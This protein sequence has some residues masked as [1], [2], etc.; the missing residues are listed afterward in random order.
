MNEAD[1]EELAAILAGKAGEEKEDGSFSR[2]ADSLP[3]TMPPTNT[4][5]AGASAS[6]MPKG[7]KEIPTNTRRPLQPRSVNIQRDDP[8]RSRAQ[9]APHNDTDEILP[10]KP[11]KATG[12]QAE[13]N[14]E[15]A[16]K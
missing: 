10:G 3:P 15:N 16:A 7:R 1:T 2:A 11:T 4:H 13:V 9:P 8:A 12:T 5:G 14:A 6:A